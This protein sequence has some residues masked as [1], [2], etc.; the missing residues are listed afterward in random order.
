MVDMMRFVH[1]TNHAGQLFPCQTSRSNSDNPS[2]NSS[3]VFNAS[4][5][6]ERLFTAKERNNALIC[7][8]AKIFS[9]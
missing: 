4:A 2:T 3:S 7:G 6:A 8:D 9:G 1:P 5:F